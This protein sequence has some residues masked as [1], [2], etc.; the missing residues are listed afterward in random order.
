MGKKSIEERTGQIPSLEPD[1]GTSIA[2]CN[3]YRKLT[4]I[5]GV[6]KS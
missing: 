6:L 5:H 2:T 1:F 4:V 3:P